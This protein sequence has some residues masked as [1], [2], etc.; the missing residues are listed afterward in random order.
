M[1]RI[2]IK[3]IPE[4]RKASKEEMKKVFGGIIVDNKFIIDD[5]RFWSGAD[6]INLQELGNPLSSAGF[7]RIGRIG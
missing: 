7:S 1:A 3:D 6:L 5:G 4:E 2:K